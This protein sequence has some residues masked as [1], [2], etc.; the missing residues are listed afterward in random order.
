MALSAPH[1]SLSVHPVVHVDHMKVI[2]LQD[3]LRS[4]SE[5]SER[6]HLLAVYSSQT[7]PTPEIRGGVF[8]L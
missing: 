2:S 3:M 5:M 4:T 7:A 8:S 1:R 6:V